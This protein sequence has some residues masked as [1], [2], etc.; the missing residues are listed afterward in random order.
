MCSPPHGSRKK[1]SGLVKSILYGSLE[2]QIE[3][4]DMEQKWSKILA[5]GK[6]MQAIEVH[7]VKPD[8]VED[9]FVLVGEMYPAIARDAENKCLL[10]RS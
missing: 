5:R 2:G 8:R 1:K 10:I 7:C 6:Y 9:S 3:E 4:A